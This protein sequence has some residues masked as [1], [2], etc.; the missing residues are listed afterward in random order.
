MDLHRKH[1]GFK[2]IANEREEE[3]IKFYLEFK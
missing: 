2:I 1:P 3:G